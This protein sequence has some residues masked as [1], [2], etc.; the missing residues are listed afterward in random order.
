MTCRSKQPIYHLH[1][2]VMGFGGVTSRTGHEIWLEDY[3]MHGPRSARRRRSR[4]G[5]GQI[6]PTGASA[7][8]QAMLLPE[9]SGHHDGRMRRPT[10]AATVA[11]SRR[12]RP[13]GGIGARDREGR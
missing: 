1:H 10:S 7:G 13:Q 3:D 8:R 12:A 9:V 6:A 2:L 5:F 11:V 4:L